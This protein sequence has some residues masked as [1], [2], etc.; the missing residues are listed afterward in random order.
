VVQKLGPVSTALSLAYCFGTFSFANG[1]SAPA[2]NNNGTVSGI[3][4]NVDNGRTVAITYDNLNHVSTATTQA[5]SGPDCWGQ[6][7]SQP[8]AN[9]ATPIDRWNNLL[10]MY[11]TQC[12]V[13]GLSVSVDQTKNQINAP[14]GYQYDSSGNGN[15]TNDGSYAYTYDAENHITSA[16]GVNYTYDG[17]GVRVEK[18]NGT[19][20]WRT[21][22]GSV[23]AETDLNGNTKNEYVYFAGVQK[24][25]WDGS[26]N[27]YYIHQDALGSTRTITQ[28]NGTVCYD[29]DFT[30][31][32]QEIQHI[33]NCP[34]T[35]NYKFT[36]YERDSETGLDYAFAR[37]YNS[38][39]GRFMSPDP[40]SGDVTSPQSL[41]RY[42]YVLNIPT[43][44]TDPFGL[45]C[46]SDQPCPNPQWANAN[47]PTYVVSED[48]A[49][50]LNGGFQVGTIITFDINGKPTGVQTG[51]P[52]MAGS[53][54]NAG[55]GSA[56]FW[57]PG[58]VTSL[59]WQNGVL[60]VTYIQFGGYPTQGVFDPESGTFS[61]AYGNVAWNFADYNSS[62]GSF[63]SA[64]VSVSQQIY[65]E[66][67]T[68]VEDLGGGVAAVEGGTAAL[69]MGAVAL[70][71]AVP[72]LLDLYSAGELSVYSNP[73]AVFNAIDFVGG[74]SPFP[75]PFTAYGYAGNMVAWCMTTSCGSSN[76][77]GH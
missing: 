31:F 3:Q 76:G 45:T 16:N 77:N 72:A 17:N 57:V 15:M 38:R 51:T 63:T 9:N 73:A 39:L 52:Q 56:S 41:N 18:S 58:A 66:A 43:S 54:D 1:C 65:G 22:T 5:T 74:F 50:F 14:P 19:L 48:Q 26:G 10:N 35:Y 12:S 75:G 8:P 11:V 34:S 60:T 46:R 64:Q 36:G 13:G 70:A 53:M 62:P 59:Q 61:D 42:A 44:L 2:A 7:Y 37:Y 21:I 55:T 68:G 24:A 29:A 47:F 67:S 71:P 20:Y 23:L 25:W 4:N 30:P 69:A 49:F 28:T 32:G 40:L 6:A 33:N 27:L